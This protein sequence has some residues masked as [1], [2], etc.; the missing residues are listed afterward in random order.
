MTNT[1]PMTNRVAGSGRRLPMRSIPDRT[2]AASFG[3][4]LFTLE[5]LRKNGF[6]LPKRLADQLYTRFA[7]AHLERLDRDLDSVCIAH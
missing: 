7:H 5:L 4:A 3:I 2:H 6:R 1:V